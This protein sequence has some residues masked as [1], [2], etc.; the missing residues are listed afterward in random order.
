MSAEPRQPRAF[1][2]DDPALVTE[3]EPDP[4]PRASPNDTQDTAVAR[5]TL[6]DMGRRGA[7]WGA[8]LIA[9]LTGAA[10]LGLAAWFARIVSAALARDDWVGTATLGLLFTAAFAA[11]M[12]AL[13]ELFGFLRLGRLNRLRSDVGIALEQ[14]DRKRERRAAL[15]LAALYA[16]RCELAWG[17]K[18]FRDHVRDVHDPGELL[19]LADREILIPLDAEARRII[20]RSAKRVATVTALSPMVLIAVTYVLIENLRLLRMLATLYGARPGFL[21][22]TKLAR[23]VFVHIVATG[24]MAMTDDLLG[25]FLGQDLL[26]RLS[27][28]LGEG[29]FNGALTARIGV[30]AL[31]VIRPLP[32]LAAKPPR[33][34]DIL[35]EALKPIFSARKTDSA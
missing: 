5:P 1:K 13:R 7:R 22:V 32:F 19:G 17:V 14:R 9:A 25:Q 30:T 11:L 33:V 28:R 2:V 10:V 26:R 16:G 6:A 34:R 18:R 21:G 15:R 35:T 24:G 27:R 29:A 12:I 8:L 3:P 31:E 23:L 4:A 20:T